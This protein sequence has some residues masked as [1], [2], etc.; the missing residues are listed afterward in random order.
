[1]IPPLLNHPAMM[2]LNNNN[3]KKG[4]VEEYKLIFRYY[5]PNKNI[6]QT[7]Q[8]KYVFIDREAKKNINKLNPG[9][10][11]FIDGK[12]HMLKNNTVCIHIETIKNITTL[13][14]SSSIFTVDYK[15]AANDRTKI[16]RNIYKS[17]FWQLPEN[18]GL[19]DNNNN[20]NKNKI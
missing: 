2:S 16:Y 18:N 4:G 10:I 3:N 14:S 9:Y 6:A 1:M 15:R 20:N 13:S 8:G 17:I 11:W 5:I 7:V 12:L 19:L